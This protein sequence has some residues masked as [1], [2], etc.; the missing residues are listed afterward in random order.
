[1]NETFFQNKLVLVIT[2][3]SVKSLSLS[4][5]KF[6]RQKSLFTLLNNTYLLLQYNCLLLALDYGDRLSYK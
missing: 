2:N 6:I 3:V 5:W 1:M 4:L